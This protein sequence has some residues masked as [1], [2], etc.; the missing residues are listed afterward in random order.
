MQG[1]NS[2]DYQWCLCYSWTSRELH[3]VSCYAWRQILLTWFLPCPDYIKELPS[4]ISPT[5]GTALSA[6]HTAPRGCSKPCNSPS[7][8]ISFDYLGPDFA[9]LIS[10]CPDYIKGASFL[11]LLYS[12]HSSESSTHS[13]QGCFTRLQQPFYTT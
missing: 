7:T 11:Y 1:T 4:F 13:P 2:P 9:R 5:P 3:D 8:S 12:R 10:S 6:P